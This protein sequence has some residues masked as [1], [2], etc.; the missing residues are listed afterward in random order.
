MLEIVLATFL[1]VAAADYPRYSAFYSC[2]GALQAQSDIRNGNML[3]GRV[4]PKHNENISTMFDTGEKIYSQAERDKGIE[5]FADSIELY[6]DLDKKARMRLLEK[7]FEVLNK[8][9]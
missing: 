6:Q 2:L 1:T 3:G 8:I 9:K 4:F 5:I 7:C